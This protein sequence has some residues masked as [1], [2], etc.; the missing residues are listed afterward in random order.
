MT[1]PAPAGFT[2][3][4]HGACSSLPGA[5]MA[6]FGICMK[7]SYQRSPTSPPDRIHSSTADDSATGTTAPSMGRWQLWKL[8]VS[9]LGRKDMK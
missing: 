5:L 1:K 9:V 4:W 8:P 6:K 3:D 7:D 2:K